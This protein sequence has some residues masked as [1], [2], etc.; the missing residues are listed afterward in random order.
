MR[1]MSPKEQELQTRR[2]Y[3]DAGRPQ[4]ESTGRVLVIDDHPVS[5]IVAKR[6]LFRLGF[7]V[8]CVSDLDE[9]GELVEEL[10]YAAVLVNIESP[11]IDGFETARQIHQRGG[12]ETPV[13]AMVTNPTTEVR[14]RCLSAGIAHL[15]YRP[16]DTVAVGAVL[17]TA[18]RPGAVSDGHRT[19]P[20]QGDDDGV[21]DLSRLEDLAELVAPDG[22]N[23]MVSM[24][25]SFARRSAERTGALK[26]AAAAGDRETVMSVAHELKGASG[27]IGAQRVMSCAAV[28]EQQARGGQDPTPESIDDLLTEMESAVRSL[29]EHVAQ[30]RF[31]QPIG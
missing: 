21:I 25:E 3:T 16:L 20:V 14:E 5:R 28:I 8:R 7:D 22:T 23:L 19:T 4:V 11:S 10:P 30:P 12:R 2:L 24:V 26:D 9:A 18:A 27:T 6:L 1:L 13:V 17:A 31:G 29:A 15:V